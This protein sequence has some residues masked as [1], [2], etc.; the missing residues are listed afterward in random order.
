MKTLIYAL[1][2]ASVFKLICGAYYVGMGFK[3]KN[4][5]DKIPADERSDIAGLGK[6][7]MVIIMPQI[8]PSS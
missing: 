8:S 1:Q 6:Y 4:I 5:D 3:E 7:T 2:V